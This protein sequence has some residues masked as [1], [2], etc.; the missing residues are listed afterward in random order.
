MIG[1]KGIP[2][3]GEFGGGIETH[4]EELATRLAARGHRVFVYV[5]PWFQKESKR[6]HGKV[7]L[8]RKWTL[9]SKNLETIIHTFLCTLDVLFKRADIIHYHGVGPSTIA[10][11]P[12]VFK[13]DAKVVV[14][15]H[16]QDRFH[17]KWGWFARFY[18]G[19]GEWTACRFAHE[20]ICVSHNLQ[21]YCARKF[22]AKTH[23][24]PNGVEIQR[25]RK[26]TELKQFGLAPNEYF[27]VVA[28]LVQHKGIHYLIQA[29]QG[30]K[31]RKKLVI[32]GAPSFSGQYLKF[33]QA[34]AEGRRNII[35]TG[36]RTGETLKQLFANT[37]A[38]VHPSESEGLSITILEAMSFG[39]CVLISDIPEN[40]E[41]IDH[42]GF[43]FR[44]G[45]V[46]DLRKKMR[47]LLENPKVVA[48]KGG[49]ARQ[50][51]VKYFNWDEIV[52]QTQSLYSQL[53]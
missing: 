27:L 52:E 14:T 45:S 30:L 44:S 13:R 32:V 39:K 12:R 15:F 16:S 5:R 53:K 22:R 18:L 21:I 37:Y 48:K 47:Y 33:L 35:F 9:K 10:W 36:F 26:N 20:T 2:R 38:Y 11:L 51:M 4:V 46:L 23:Y 7:T 50:F 28:R 25:S 1:Q 6:R 34:L 8:L 31:T 29:F 41:T 19:W 17:K 49:L 24:I 43:S 3:M 42:S 40:L